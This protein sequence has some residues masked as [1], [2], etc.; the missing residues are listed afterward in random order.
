MEQGYQREVS[1]ARD[2]MSLANE[3][4]MIWP[5][6]LM[7]EPFSQMKATLRS[8]RVEGALDACGL[9]PLRVPLNG[10][11]RICT[12]LARPSPD[13]FSRMVLVLVAL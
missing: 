4:G 3:D 1:H 2:A 6:I 12:P 11:C 13:D 10:V 8:A 9:P 5:P 7:T